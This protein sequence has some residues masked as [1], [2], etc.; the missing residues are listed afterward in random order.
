MFVQ[1]K[2]YYDLSN[3][4]DK[5]VFLAGVNG[6]ICVQ[7]FKKILILSSTD[8]STWSMGATHSFYLIV[9]FSAKSLVSYI[10]IFSFLFLSFF[11]FLHRNDVNIWTNSRINVFCPNCL[12]LII[13]FFL[14][15]GFSFLFNDD[16]SFH[17]YFYLIALLTT[18]L[19]SKFINANQIY[20]G[21]TSKFINVNQIYL[22]E[23]GF[24]FL[25]ISLHRFHSFICCLPN[26]II[27]CLSVMLW[28]LFCFFMKV[29]FR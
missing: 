21:L 24:I 20:T 27:L 3:V 11:S 5:C 28:M 23:G 25:L 4:C 16:N 15:K 13:V 12:I 7:I 19:T 2:F 22:E 18:G 6:F 1:K 29:I 9:L 17:H 26:Y 10:Y 14:L 8:Y